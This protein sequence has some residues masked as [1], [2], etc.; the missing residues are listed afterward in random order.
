VVTGAV[1]N[2]IDGLRRALGA[3]A[4]QRIAPHCT[5]IPPVNVAEESLAAVLDHSRAAAAA[6][7]PIPVTLGPPATFWP[8]T[9]VI[10]LAV[11]GDVSSVAGLRSRLAAGPLAP[12]TARKEREFVPHVTLDQQI[13][14]SRLPNAL[15]ALAD[16]R[17]DYCFERLSILEQ[18]ASH[19]WQPLSDLPL[20]KPS[21]AGRG[22]LDLQLSV[23]DRAD[24]VV[25]A[26]ADEIWAHYSRDT[27]G[28]TV[29][30]VKSFAIVARAEGRQ[31]G[32]AEGEIRGPVCRL[33]RVIVSPE[34]RG[35][36]IG[37]HLLRAVERLGSERGCTRVRIE[38]LAGGRAQRFYT[39][40]GY[41]VTAALPKWREE[42]DFALM[43]R[44]I[45]GSSAS[46]PAVAASAPVAA[47]AAQERIADDSSKRFTT[48]S[49]E[50]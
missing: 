19:R 32:L 30:P 31:V 3:A 13:E 47:L 35:Q 29:R 10:Y 49:D 28:E 16:Y 21:V 50:S 25:A 48:D 44:H 4:L 8:R 33:S 17:T 37:S 11:A 39:D 41:V 20:G 46:A 14:A 22:S 43:E 5:L 26:W 1:A 23:V 36:G 38:A 15:A 7:G 40:R 18:D 24:P 34:R 27:Y 12:P 2:E 6:Y 9:P 45:V 42:R